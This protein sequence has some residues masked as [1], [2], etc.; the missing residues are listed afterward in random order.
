M[1]HWSNRDGLG[2]NAYN[3]HKNGGKIAGVGADLSELASPTA[4][5]LAPA[6]PTREKQLAFN[7]ALIAASG[8]YLA[9]RNGH[10]KFATVAA[11][12]TTAFVKAVRAGCKKP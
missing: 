11:G 3:V 12:N 8:G 1:V 4:F 9:L 2:L 6:G 5:E 7:D 10:E